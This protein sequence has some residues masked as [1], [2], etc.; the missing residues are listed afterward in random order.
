MGID[1]FR[2]TQQKTPGGHWH[3]GVSFRLTCALEETLELSTSHWVLK[4]PYRLGLDLSNPFTRDLEDP[5]HFL[6]RV[7]VAVA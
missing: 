1:S 2:S 4:F 7:S 5:A 6:E 3:P